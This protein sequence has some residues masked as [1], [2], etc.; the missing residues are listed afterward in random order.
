MLC[1]PG[2]LSDDPEKRRVLEIPIPEEKFQKR[3]TYTEIPELAQ[4]QRP[5]LKIF[6]KY[7]LLKY[8]LRM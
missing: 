2:C 7:I 1:I 5:L 3:Y 6:L 8:I 4:V